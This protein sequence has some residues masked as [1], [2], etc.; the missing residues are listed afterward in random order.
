METNH[1]L[2]LL[3]RAHIE[4]LNLVDYVVDDFV[5][6][7]VE[8]HSQAPAA[9]GLLTL[10][11][12]FK[13][14][15]QNGE[16][17]F[18]VAYEATMRQFARQRVS[19]LLERQ[20]D[21]AL[22]ALWVELGAYPNDEF[23]RGDNCPTLGQLSADLENTTYYRI[24]ERAKSEKIKYRPGYAPDV[25]RQPVGTEKAEDDAQQNAGG[26]MTLFG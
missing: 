23:L 24:Y 10:W 22:A 16:S 17:V 3:T 14:Q 9:M 21:L 1:S 18:F 5:V 11:D 7:D 12:E 13:E 2:M 26:Q 8:R 25:V 4:I 6:L 15:V 19:E 20:D